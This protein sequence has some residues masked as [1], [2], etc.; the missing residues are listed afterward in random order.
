VQFHCELPKDYVPVRLP[1]GAHLP[2]GHH[3]IWR[4]KGNLHLAGFVF[5]GDRDNPLRFLLVDQQG[6]VYLFGKGRVAYENGTV[7]ALPPVPSGSPKPRTDV[8]GP[9]VQR[10]PRDSTAPFSFRPGTI[11]DYDALRRDPEEE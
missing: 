3:S 9:S 6:L 5:S 10:S 11:E 1:E 4:I 2:T 8:S 7:V